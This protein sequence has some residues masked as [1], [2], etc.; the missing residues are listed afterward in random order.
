MIIDHLREFKGRHLVAVVRPNALR[1]LPALQFLLLAKLISF[2]LLFLLTGL[3][4]IQIIWVLWV[5]ILHIF[6]SFFIGVVRLVYLNV[7]LIRLLPL[8][9]G[10]FLEQL[11]TKMVIYEFANVLMIRFLFKVLYCIHESLDF[12]RLLHVH[13]FILNRLW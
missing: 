6:V 4:S 2:L 9:V 10:H 13:L 8:D 12:F 1:E 11:L 7:C 3:P 5:L